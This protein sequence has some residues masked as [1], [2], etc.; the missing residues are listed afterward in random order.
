MAFINKYSRLLHIKHRQRNILSFFNLS[1]FAHNFASNKLSKQCSKTIRILLG[2]C[3]S[4][5]FTMSFVLAYGLYKKLKFLS[6]MR[7]KLIGIIIRY[8]LIDSQQV[9]FVNSN[10]VKF[11]LN[12]V[13][14]QLSKYCMKSK[15]G[16]VTGKTKTK[17]KTKTRNGCI[18][19]FNEL[20]IIN[21]V[22]LT[23][24]T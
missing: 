5:A 12:V 17:T 13:C 7:T 8:H 11:M 2:F 16:Q 24:I 15:A 6:C 4:F 19:D 9:I 10:I 20:N 3:V 18:F 1:L 23:I 14:K 21:K 22:I